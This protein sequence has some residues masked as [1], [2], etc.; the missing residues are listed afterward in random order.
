MTAVASEGTPVRHHRLRQ[1]LRAAVLGLT[2]SPTPRFRRWRDPRRADA[3]EATPHT[4]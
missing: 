1:R 4:T 2:R 3:G